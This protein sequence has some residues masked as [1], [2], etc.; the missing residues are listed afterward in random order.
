MRL[1]ILLMGLSNPCIKAGRFD[2]W[3]AACSD[4]RARWILSWQCPDGP[5]LLDLQ[6]ST[7]GLQVCFDSGD[8]FFV[9]YLGSQ[10]TGINLNPPGR[11]VVISCRHQGPQRSSICFSIH[12]TV[13]VLKQTRCECWVHMFE[14]WSSC[15]RHPESRRVSLSI[16]TAH[17]RMFND[18]DAPEQ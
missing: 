17:S 18:T 7:G 12:S 6:I 15:D 1:T 14:S 4:V 13:G 5:E 3:A 9:L 11:K 2:R 16:G 10:W 8:G